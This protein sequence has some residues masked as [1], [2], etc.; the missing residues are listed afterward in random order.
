V[1]GVEA[2]E[3][4]LDPM[5]GSGTVPIE[6]AIM[7]INSIG[8]DISPFCRFMAQ[9]KYD[10]L[11][12]KPKEV[13]NQIILLK[14]LFNDLEKHAPEISSLA[15]QNAKEPLVTNDPNADMFLAL[16]Y[17]DAMG[18]AARVTSKDHEGLFAELLEKYLTV[19]EKFWT[20]NASLGLDLGNADL[21][22]GD[23]RKLEIKSNSIGGCIFSPPY[24]FAIDYAENDEDQLKLMGID[25]SHLRE[26]M[27]GLRGG[28]SAERVDLYFEDMTQTMSEI[29]R[30]LQPQR[31]CV[32]VVGSNTS[33]LKTILKTDDAE[34][35]S[36]ENRLMHIGD[37]VGLK[38]AEKMTRQVTG[39]RN[40]MRDEYLLFFQK[41]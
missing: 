1:I 9:A 29:H 25:V 30:V 38:F 8:V 22:E 4:V 36:I 12:I 17:Y 13:K 28:K 19:A 23:S 5:M 26:T 20:V 3:T 18:Y 40:V 21:R 37:S 35:I 6:A 14:R 33:Q 27:I 32:I 16:C 34:L 10:G 2:G 41:A 39:I 7:G 11:L 24:S 31:Y 15:F